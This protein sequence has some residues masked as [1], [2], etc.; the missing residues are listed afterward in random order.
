MR[1]CY[2]RL[3]FKALQNNFSSKPVPPPS[4]QNTAGGAPPLKNEDLVM[5]LV[6]QLNAKVQTCQ[7][8]MTQLDERLS[9]AEI[10]IEE[11]LIE[12]KMYADQKEEKTV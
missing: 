4:P 5:K 2:I 11:Q 3:K 7:E 6:N 12:A 9:K 8:Q 10:K 1:D